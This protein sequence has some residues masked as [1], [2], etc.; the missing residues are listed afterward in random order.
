MCTHCWVTA[1]FWAEVSPSR[2]GET[3]CHRLT[4]TETLQIPCN[5]TEQQK[6]LQHC[7]AKAIKALGVIVKPQLV[8][9]PGVLPPFSFTS[10][11]VCTPAFPVLGG[12]HCTASGHSHDRF[13]ANSPTNRGYFQRACHSLHKLIGWQGYHYL[14]LNVLFVPS[15]LWNTATCQKLFC[16]RAGRVGCAVWVVFRLRTQPLK[17]T[18]WLN[19][20]QFRDEW[21]RSKWK[22]W[23]PNHAS[24][25]RK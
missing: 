24:L 5:R 4:Y 13:I 6:L 10:S 11:V 15:N 22:K 16:A 17:V 7:L 12:F 8:S 14:S 2:S 19:F 20:L 25:A 1:F 3:Q 21:M 23:K 9:N 18:I